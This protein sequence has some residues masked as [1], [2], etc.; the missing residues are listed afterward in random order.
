[1]YR[2]YQHMQ[3][4]D[5]LLRSLNVLVPRTLARGSN[6]RLRIPRTHEW[7]THRLSTPSA[8]EG[9]VTPS[10]RK[11]ITRPTTTEGRYYSDGFAIDPLAR[12]RGTNAY[13]GN[14]TVREGASLTCTLPNGR[15]SARDA[16]DS[17]CC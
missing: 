13:C 6:A 17:K 2:S 4:K 5:P 9:L 8:S 1:M 11:W 15:V 16:P 12:A 10:V 14:P 7:I 3:C